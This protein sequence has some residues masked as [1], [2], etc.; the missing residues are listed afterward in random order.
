MAWIQIIPQSHSFQEKSVIMSQTIDTGVKILSVLPIYKL[1][2]YIASDFM[3]WNSMIS[4]FNIT[5]WFTP[6]FLG[7]TVHFV[8]MSFSSQKIE[9]VCSS[10]KYDIKTLFLC[11]DTAIVSWRKNKKVIPSFLMEN[12]RLFWEG[13]IQK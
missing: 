1:L 4:N 3:T 2:I 7:S 6:F 12:Y 11:N 8:E 13:E 5:T 9:M 10:W